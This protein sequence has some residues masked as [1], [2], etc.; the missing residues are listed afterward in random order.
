VTNAMLKTTLE[1][2]WD[3]ARKAPN[4]QEATFLLLRKLAAATVYPLRTEV[5]KFST[6]RNTFRVAHIRTGSPVVIPSKPGM[7]W[8]VI[9]GNHKPVLYTET[10]TKLFPYDIE[11]ATQVAVR[12]SN[13]HRIFHTLADWMIVR[14][15]ELTSKLLR[16][17]GHTPASCKATAGS[18]RGVLAIRR[19]I[20]CI[21]VYHKNTNR[22]G[23]MAW[24]S[25]AMCLPCKEGF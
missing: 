12:R 18:K 13:L 9:S 17:A 6:A 2:M 23:I 19:D 15:N 14:E 21:P 16:K 5:R 25:F 4:P 7:Q 10:H 3:K 20:D 11:L 24:E 22:W 1:T 8:A